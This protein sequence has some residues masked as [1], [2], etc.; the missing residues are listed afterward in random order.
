M[1]FFVARES[2]V[3]VSPNCVFDASLVPG[4]CL[5]RFIDFKELINK[6]LESRV[7]GEVLLGGD[8]TWPVCAAR[9]YPAG[10]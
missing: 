3:L 5:G 2:Q 10:S 1:Q 8:F 7:T 6:F 4:T 9:T